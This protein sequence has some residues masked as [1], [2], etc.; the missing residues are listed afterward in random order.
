[1]VNALDILTGLLEKRATIERERSRVEAEYERA[2]L[3]KQAFEDNL[4]SLDSVI[5]MFKETE[6]LESDTQPIDKINNEAETDNGNKP[7]FH[8]KANEN[9]HRPKRQR[10]G[11][12]RTARNFF[13]EL[14]TE[15]TKNNVAEILIREHPEL[16]GK[17]NE[18]TL[19]SVIK[20]FIDSKEARIK[21]PASGTS[22]QIYEKV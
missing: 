18:N 9:G 14:P 6:Q 3:R 5:K 20:Q 10:V 16:N 12:N 8:L 7:V 21:T 22:P 11:L 4:A 1:M 13:G 2:C 19:R 15:Y 17:V